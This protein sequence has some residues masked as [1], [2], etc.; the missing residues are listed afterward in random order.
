MTDTGTPY[1]SPATLLE[2]LTFPSL[3]QAH[4]E[5]LLVGLERSNE[6]IALGITG[7]QLDRL[8]LTAADL[9]KLGITGDEISPMIHFWWRA[10]T[11]NIT[12]DDLL[13]YARQRMEQGE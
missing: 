5:G 6:F 7:E 2:R 8:L 11:L 13:T 12:A 3:R 1:D 10:Q 4:I 9:A